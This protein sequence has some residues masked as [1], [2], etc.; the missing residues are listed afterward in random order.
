MPFPRL[1]DWVDITLAW[2]LAVPLNPTATMDTVTR[3]VLSI[4]WLAAITTALVGCRQPEEKLPQG[5]TL[6]LVLAQNQPLK[7]VYFWEDSLQRQLS[8]ELYHYDQNQFFRPLN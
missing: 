4:S 6:Q 2:L 7:P 8:F 1:P 5:T 3:F